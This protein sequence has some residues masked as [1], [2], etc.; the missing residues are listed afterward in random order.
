MDPEVDRLKKL[1]SE[2]QR[3]IRNLMDQL[4]AYERLVS[5]M[6]MLLTT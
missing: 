4:R 3:V 1:V 2:Q 6:S 5:D